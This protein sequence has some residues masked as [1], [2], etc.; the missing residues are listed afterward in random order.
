MP[1]KH[2]SLSGSCAVERRR[3]AACRLK[4]LFPIGVLLVGLAGCT[5]TSD[6]PLISDD[7]AAFPFGAVVTVLPP[8]LIGA[9]GNQD[10]KTFVRSGS[11]YLVADPGDPAGNT[12]TFRFMRVADGQFVIQIGSGSTAYNCPSSD[13]LA[14]LAA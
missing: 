5:Y 1:R 12:P 11:D 6:K 7:K 3:E 9:V 13:H 14:Q 4:R 10:S 2:T 8:P